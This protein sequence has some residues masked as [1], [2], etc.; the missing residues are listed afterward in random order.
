MA[1]EIQTFFVCR[2]IAKN[3]DGFN[4]AGAAI[5]EILT[6]IF[7]AQV[8]VQFFMMLRKE[9]ADAEPPVHADIRI[10]NQDGQMVYGPFENDF[11]FAGNHRFAFV[12]GLLH[13]TF[14]VP[15]QYT[16][17]VLISSADHVAEYRY[18]L[19]LIHQDPPA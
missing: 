17:T 1:A 3:A 9:N 10:H 14:P 19:D 18:D 7:P 4:V 6:N 13:V 12:P 16:I 11:V 8:Q 2:E 5:N 15:D